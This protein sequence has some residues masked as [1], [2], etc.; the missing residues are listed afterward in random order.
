M[1]VR[2]ATPDDRGFFL[3]LWWDYL[4]EMREKGSE[5]LPTERTLD[6]YATVLDSYLTG[7]RVGVAIVQYPI[8]VSMAGDATP[9]WDSTQGQTAIG[10]G[11]YVE[12][13][14]RSRGVARKIRDFVIAELTKQ[15]FETLLGTVGVGDPEALASIRKV[16]GVEIR[17]YVY[18]R[19]LT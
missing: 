17:Q 18:R 7:E 8:A 19:R 3:R 13:G 1:S 4:V 5:I 16:P 11:T 12:P 9:A 14:F 15:G 2:L 10:W 6:F